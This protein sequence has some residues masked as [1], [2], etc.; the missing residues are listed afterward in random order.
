[1]ANTLRLEAPR[2]SELMFFVVSR[3]RPDRYDSLARAFGADPDVRVIFDRRRADR[4]R[5][6][7]TPSTDRRRRERRSDLRAWTLRTTGWIRVPV[8]DAPVASARPR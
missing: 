5:A 7:E 2:R 1:M 8:A 6:T 4:R 3:E